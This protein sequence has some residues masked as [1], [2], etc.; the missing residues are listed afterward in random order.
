MMPVMNGLELAARIQQATSAAP[1]LV[2]LTSDPAVDPARAA[3][4]GFSYALT[5][6][7]HSGQLHEALVELVGR[8]AEDAASTTSRVLVIDENPTNQLITSGMVEYLGYQATTASD[9]VEALI[10]LARVRYD[11]VLVDCRLPLHEELRTVGEIR[12][13]HGPD[14]HVPV[15]AMTT[16]DLDD[17]LEDL[18]SAGID[19]HVARPITLDALGG[20][21]ERWV[22]PADRS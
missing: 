4:A 17:Q 16:G 12:R 19:D 13:F 22:V 9:E 6:P 20:V 15:V 18:R 2:L 14:A 10:A 11:A 1:R 3:Q 8:G 5:K 21:L 7:V